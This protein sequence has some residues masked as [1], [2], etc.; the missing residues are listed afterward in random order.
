VG[1]TGT[2]KEKRKMEDTDRE[3]EEDGEMARKWRNG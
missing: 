1:N 2:K 3:K